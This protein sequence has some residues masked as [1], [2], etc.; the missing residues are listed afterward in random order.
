MK[1]LIK[2]ITILLLLIGT[3]CYG[4]KMVQKAS[5]AKK[6][7]INKEQFSGKPLRV[8]LAQIEPAIKFVYGNPENKWATATGGTYLKFHF[9]DRG[10][11][12]KKI[13]KNKKPLGILV[14]FQLDLNNTHKSLPKQGL[15]EWTDENT[16]MYGDMIITKVRVIGGD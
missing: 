15:N 14:T 16:S 6:L 13:N 9:I 5:D 2:L 4:Q 3:S 11:Y 7:E 8:L 10:D 12:G 1:Q